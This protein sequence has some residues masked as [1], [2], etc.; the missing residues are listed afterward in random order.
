MRYTRFAPLNLH[1]ALR[2]S[3]A[4]VLSWYV[5]AAEYIV[6]IGSERYDAR[7]G[8]CVLGPRNVPHAFA[9]AGGPPGR[10]LISFT[11]AGKMEEFF[12]I[13]RKPGEYT[14][15]SAL[16]ERYGMKLLGP[17]LSL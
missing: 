7:A 1:W 14:D 8:D 5:I 16:W 17:P 12:A 10:I 9:F 13:Q 15:K 2:R 3:A 4:K 11:P 6:E